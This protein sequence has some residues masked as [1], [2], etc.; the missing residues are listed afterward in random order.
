L[1]PSNSG[2]ILE[3]PDES[4]KDLWSGVWPDRRLP[5]KSHVC[6]SFARSCSMSDVLINRDGWAPASE[7]I[8]LPK[9]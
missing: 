5:K 8:N 9:L 4:F 2:G 3:M 6:R 1:K 7:R